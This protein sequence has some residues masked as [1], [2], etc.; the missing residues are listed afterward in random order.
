MRV[1]E[2]ITPIGDGR[3]DEMVAAQSFNRMLDF[4][5]DCIVGFCLRLNEH[6]LCGLPPIS[7]TIAQVPP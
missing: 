7:R 6:F 5:D 2:R 3:Q 1:W 4:F